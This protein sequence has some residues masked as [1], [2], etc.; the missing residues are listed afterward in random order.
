VLFR[1][2]SGYDSCGCNHCAFQR[3]QIYYHFVVHVRCACSS[4][5]SHTPGNCSA[6]IQQASGTRRPD[7]RQRC[8]PHTS[9]RHG[10]APHTRF[11][12]EVSP[13]PHTARYPLDRSD[14]CGYR[15]EVKRSRSCFVLVPLTCRYAAPNFSDSTVARSSVASA[16]LLG[17]LRRPFCVLIDL[18]YIR[19]PAMT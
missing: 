19:L 8:P 15:R 6:P 10:V 12:C 3:L 1:S 11:W 16:W 18:L 4:S 7:T 14:T 9:Q 13:T 2:F 5:S 17:L